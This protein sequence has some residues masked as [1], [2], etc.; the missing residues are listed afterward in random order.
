MAIRIIY[1]SINVDIPI[2]P[3][4]IVADWRQERSLERA[5]SGRAEIINFYGLIEIEFDARFSEAVY[6]ELLAWWSWARQG[7]TFAFAKNSGKTASTTLDGASA[8]GQKVIP[9]TS[10]TG[11]LAAG[12]KCLIATDADDAFEVIEIASVSAGMSVTAV[13]N[14]KF[15]Y[16]AGDS[17]RHLEYW[18]S[19]I[20][21]GERFRPL[22]S[23]DSYSFTFQFA[24]AE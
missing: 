14:L 24:E 2:G 6:H 16:A 17:F 22:R 19:L 12:D 3:E 21:T 23:G 20:Y 11:G 5:G 1:N 9:L 4:G 8:A 10:T 13:D 15:S 7:K 18:P